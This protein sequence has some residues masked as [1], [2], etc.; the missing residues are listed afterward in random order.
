MTLGLSTAVAL[1]DGLGL[2]GLE[3]LFQFPGGH[4]HD[5]VELL[6]DLLPVVGHGGTS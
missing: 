3:L 2:V 4:V 5:F 6:D 1:T